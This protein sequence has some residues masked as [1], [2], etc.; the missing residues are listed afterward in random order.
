MK[1]K[2]LSINHF[3]QEPKPK[4][5]DYIEGIDPFLD[6]SKYFEAVDKFIEDVKA[7]KERNEKPEPVLEMYYKP[8]Y[9]CQKHPSECYETDLEEYENK[10]KKYEENRV[11]YEGWKVV[12]DNEAQIVLCKGS[13]QIAFEYGSYKTAITETVKNGFMCIFP[14]GCTTEQFEVITG[15]EPDK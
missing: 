11:R 12:V 9:G 4:K 8:D 10:L 7:Y 13:L 5:E 3:I 1:E 2:L 15:I 6:N 14:Q